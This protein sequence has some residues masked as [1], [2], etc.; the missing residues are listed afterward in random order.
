M[1]ITI[2]NEDTYHD[3]GDSDSDNDSGN[4]LQPLI[5]IVMLIVIVFGTLQPLSS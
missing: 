5:A 4:T 2:I 3:Y 1:V